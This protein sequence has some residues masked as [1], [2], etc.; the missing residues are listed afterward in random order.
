M[1]ARMNTRFLTSGF[2]LCS[3]AKGERKYQRVSPL[4]SISSK[5]W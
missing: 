2:E 1:M 3:V 4:F 5:G